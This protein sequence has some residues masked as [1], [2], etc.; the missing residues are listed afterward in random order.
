M[1]QPSPYS[2][3]TTMPDLPEAAARV[4]A[5]LEATI[6][7]IR[8]GKVSGVLLVA[9]YPDGTD[10]GVVATLN[11]VDKVAFAHLFLATDALKTDVIAGIR[12]NT[13]ASAEEARRKVDADLAGLKEDGSP[14]PAP[15]P[16]DEP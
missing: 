13:R 4:I 7:D 6:A 11:G 9:T 12:R 5:N 3:T 10:G 2:D 1:S 14:S 16:T 8:A 15:R